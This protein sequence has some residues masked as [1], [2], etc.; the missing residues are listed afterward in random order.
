[1]QPTPDEPIRLDSPAGAAALD[2]V[3]QLARDAGPGEL[4]DGLPVPPV[5]AA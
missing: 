4:A 2:R 5:V 3:S 1:M